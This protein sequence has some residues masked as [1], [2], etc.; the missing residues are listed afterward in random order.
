MITYVKC[1]IEVT[2]V[3]YTVYRLIFAADFSVIRMSACLYQ[4]Q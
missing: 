4:L 3:L 2:S 1:S